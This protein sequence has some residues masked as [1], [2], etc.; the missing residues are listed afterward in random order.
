MAFETWYVM[1]DGSVANPRLIKRGAD[2]KLVHKDGRKVAYAS[3]GPRSRMVNLDEPVEAAPIVEEAAPEPE[4]APVEE[5][6]EK[7][8]PAS[9]DRE[10]VAEKPKPA[11]KRTYKTRGR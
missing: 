9:G 4:A 1:E 7:E 5:K 3:H 8:A 11:P 2:G 6:A 10:M